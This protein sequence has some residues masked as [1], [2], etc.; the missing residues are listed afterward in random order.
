MYTI[1]PTEYP[2]LLASVIE[3][4]P[5]TPSAVSAT[6]DWNLNHRVPVIT[7]GQMALSVR[8]MRVLPAPLPRRVIELWI[9]RLVSPEIWNVPGLRKTTSLFGQASSA[10]WIAAVSSPPL[11]ESVAQRVVRLGM[12]P[13]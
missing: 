6:G 4:E 8:R 3:L 9:S 1:S 11:G 5:L 13:L 12:P 10:A 2:G 7:I